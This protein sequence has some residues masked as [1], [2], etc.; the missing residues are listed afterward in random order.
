MISSP[1]TFCIVVYVTPMPGSTPMVV[2]DSTCIPLFSASLYSLQ[3]QFVGLKITMVARDS[4][5]IASG[6]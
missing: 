1:N 2:D 6:L 4:S 3:K 5:W